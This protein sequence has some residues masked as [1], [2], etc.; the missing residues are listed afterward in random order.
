MVRS[1]ASGS[2]RGA[3]PFNIDELNTERPCKSVRDAEVV[4]ETRQR[5]L[6]HV[7]LLGPQMRAGAR[8][9]ELRVDA[10]RASHPYAPLEHIPYTQ[11]A[12]NLPGIHGLALECERSVPG[13]DKAS[14]KS[15]QIT[16][17]VFSDAIGKVVLARIATQVTEGQHDD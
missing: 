3:R 15:R 14:G 1:T 6:I 17:Q 5:A 13:N 7:H 10:D 11:L 2:A 12:A 8:V 16:G 4:L 9:D